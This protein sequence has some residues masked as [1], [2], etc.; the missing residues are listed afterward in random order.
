MIMRVSGGLNNAGISGLY[1]TLFQGKVAMH[2]N[3]LSREFFPSNNARGQGSI[4]ASSMQYVSDIKS[5][6]SSLSDALRELSGP[7][8]SQRTIVSSNTDVMTINFTGNNPRSVGDISVQVDQIAMGQLNEGSRLNSSALYSG[9]RGVNR[10]AIETGGRTAQLSISV[11]A[12]DSNRDVQQKMAT[13]INNAGLGLR[14]TVET[15][16]QTNTSMLRVES[17]NVG[18]AERNA[19]SITDITGNAASGLG[20]NN[21]SRV[22][23]DAIYRVN[24]GQAQISQSNT[25]NLGNGVSATFRAA[26]EQPVTA[27]FGKDM[28][29][30]RGVVE[31]LVRSYNNLFSAAAGNVN[32]LKAQSLAS[33]LMNV[34]S[35]YSRSLQD[36]GI[37]FDSS[38]RM[39]VDSA[40][41]NQAFE[42][43]RLEQFFTESSGRNFG[44]GASLGR[45]ANNVQNNTSAF[46]SNSAF[47]NAWLEN[48]AYSG[49]GNP[50]QLNFP[51]AGTIF[52]YMF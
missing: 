28:N 14:A 19:F 45:L 42:N 41:L 17:T 25:V 5:A 9:D 47:N 35:A 10:F 49:F 37:G 8:F 13:A 26:S 48:F 2:N 1:N 21:I 16:S 7:A 30:V 22:R 38:G 31:S 29:F 43:G 52:D 20:A 51:S 4:S 11:A 40:R 39:T 44:F 50:I 34:S 32:D 15:D 6:S 3:R 27:T 12:G 23:Q 36:L 18:T 33:R 46:V 24:G